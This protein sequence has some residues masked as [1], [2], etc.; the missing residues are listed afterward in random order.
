MLSRSLAKFLG[1]AACVGLIVGSLCFGDRP[2]SPQMAILALLSSVGLELRATPL[3]LGFFSPSCCWAVALTGLDQL[4]LT[5]VLAC[6]ACAL[7][8]R[9]VFLRSSP[10]GALADLLVDFIPAALSAFAARGL[11]L[12]KA[13]PIYLLLVLVVPGWLSRWLAPRSRAGRDRDT[14]RAEHLALVGLGLAAAYLGK[15]HPALMLTLWPAILTL[16][17]AAFAG[18]ELDERRAQ[19]RNLRSARNQ[20]NFQEKVLTQTGERQFKMQLL[21]DARAETFELLERL[22][23]QTIEEKQGLNRALNALRDKLPGALCDFIPAGPGG[24]EFPASISLEVR[25][26]LQ[27]AWS[28]GEPW[29]NDLKTG[30]Q[31]AWPIPQRGVVLILAPVAL[32]PELKHTL[33]VFF[34]YLAVMLDRVRFQENLVQAL[35]IQASLR[36]DL[37]LAV[38]RL[39]ALLSGASEL[40][41]LVQPRQILELTVERASQWTGR[42]C[43]AFQGGIRLGMPPA[44]AMILPLAGGEFSIQAEGL[45]AAEIEA[46]QL[47]LVLAGGALQRCQA[48]AGLVQS[49]KLA[50][51]GQLAAG[52]AHEL[53]TPLGSISMACELAIKN[54]E[55]NP[56]KAITRLEMARKSIEQMRVIVSKML[57]YSRESGTGCR[58]VSM[59][60]IIKDSVQMVDQAF[61]LEGVELVTQGPDGL[62][63]VNAGEIQQVLINLLV[64][65]RLAV[66]G[67]AGAKVQIISSQVS[68]QG[69]PWLEVR[70]LDNGAGVP[71]EVVDR[72]FEPFFTTREVGT[73]VGLGLSI[74]HEILV[75]HEGELFYQPAPEGG[76]CFVIKLPICEEL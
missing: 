13:I 58:T 60:E 50:A 34:Y 75:A 37:S 8:T 35:N 19:H 69:Q 14:L 67:K 9:S 30:G 3:A 4:G 32:S 10:N 2:A 73:G 47:W 33:Q 15:V 61:Q 52:V 27:N 16:L 70:V 28:Q 31:A 39:Q 71:E 68:V 36:K 74:S 21:L 40:A 26:G 63:M 1:V 12:L 25:V 76:A 5:W 38:T 41:V 57:N 45:E 55:R 59:G 49:S 64:N 48:Q 43:A 44:Q 22:S 56:A 29:L 18:A 66:V 17:E 51:I 11:G 54:I 46:L 23:A 65:A 72:I 6:L 62:V 42:A 20:L 24:L 7:T 53:N